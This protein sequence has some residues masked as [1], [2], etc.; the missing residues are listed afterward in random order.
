MEIWI[1]LAISMWISG[2]V[3]RGMYDKRHAE[4]QEATDE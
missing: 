4:K 3:S 2:W 1:A